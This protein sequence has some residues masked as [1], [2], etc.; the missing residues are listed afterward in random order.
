MSRP[1]QTRLRVTGE[2][3][4]V[5]PLH[6]GGLGG[7]AEVDLPL[8]LDGQSH[9]YVP[10][11]SLTGALRA[12]MS[13]L[14]VDQLLVSTI[15]GP[16]DPAANDGGHASFV[17]VEDS[18]IDMPRPEV[19][20]HVRLDRL[21][22]AAA[23]DFKFDRAVLPAGTRIPLELAVDLP[24]RRPIAGKPDFYEEED[25]A[26][27]RTALGCL[28][29]CLIDTGVPLGAA[30][31]R[32]LGKTRL[33]KETLK[34]FEEDWTSATGLIQ[35]LKRDP[36]E[37]HLENIVSADAAL[38]REL[39][40]CLQKRIGIELEINWE[41][42]GPVMVKAGQDGLGVDA[43]PFVSGVGDGSHVAFTIPGSSIKGAFRS[44][45]ERIVRTVCD[46][47]AETMADLNRSAQANAQIALPLIAAVFGLGRPN[48][49]APLPK[50]MT[51]AKAA[52]AFDTCMAIN[53][54]PTSAK[55]DAVLVA[56]REAADEATGVT[57]GNGN[58]LVLEALRDADL[59]D[60]NGPRVE[61]AHHVAIDR[62]T[63]GAAEHLLFSGLEPYGVTW[64]PIRI[65]LDLARLDPSEREPAVALLLLL[66][67]DFGQNRIPIGF[68]ANRGYGSVRLKS[69][70]C[71]IRGV[72]ADDMSRHIAALNRVSLDGTLAAVPAEAR[73]GLSRAWREWIRKS[74]EQA[75]EVSA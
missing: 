4:A 22:G 38:P 28:L 59:Q 18:R 11:T 23:P 9:V 10:G 46:K 45:A 37:I 33:D 61:H 69:A 55:W 24:V 66:I 8:A 64:E 73:D 26:R 48:A 74:R 17:I 16:N 42:A 53:A 34:I 52:I 31:T 47:R 43:V 70:L 41:P 60:A 50:D 58:N 57:P 56:D 5:S 35:I 54:R 75:E 40:I 39:R 63:G 20:D 2:L 27:V 29:N 15:W 62:W 44:Q 6:V 72:D 49:R 67:R 13:S 14:L 25:E 68:G 30:Q 51:S 71:Q 36:K 32:G 12:T 1:R 3:V 21:T 7:G 65:S 19:W